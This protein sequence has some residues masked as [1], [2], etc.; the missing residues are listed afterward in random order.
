MGWNTCTSVAVAVTNVAGGVAALAA[1]ATGNRR[2]EIVNPPTNTLQMKLLIGAGTIAAA[3]FT[4][5]LNPGDVWDSAD[6]D[7]APNQA[8][9]AFA[10]GAGPENIMVNVYTFA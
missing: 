10:S 3:L 6:E 1:L 2:V 7:F 9:R 4:K 8:I 5:Y